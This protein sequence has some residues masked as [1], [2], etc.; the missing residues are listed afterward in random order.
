[1]LAGQ[2]DRPLPAADTFGR[3]APT[4]LPRAHGSRGGDGRLLERRMREVLGRVP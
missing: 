3:W 2:T 4:M 1:M